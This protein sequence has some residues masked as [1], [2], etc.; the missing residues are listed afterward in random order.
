MVFQVLQVLVEEEEVLVELD[1]TGRLHIH[2]R[3]VMVV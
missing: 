2:I 3:V 1:R